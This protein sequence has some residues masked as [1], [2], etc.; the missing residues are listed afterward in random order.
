[1]VKRY[2]SNIE[3]ELNLCNIL[4]GDEGKVFYSPCFGPIRLSVIN[5]DNILFLIVQNS[6]IYEGQKTC[7][8][9]GSNGTYIDGGEVMVYPSKD[10][11]DWFEYDYIKRNSPGWDEYVKETG[12]NIAF[13]IIDIDNFISKN[14][15]EKSAIAYIKLYKIIKH[16]YNDTDVDHIEHVAIDPMLNI[17]YYCENQKEYTP[18]FFTTTL[19]AQDFLKNPKNKELINQFYNG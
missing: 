1:M 6:K 11:R 8:I 2:E 12:D 14:K 5:E 9:L 10:N 13:D 7:I 3:C 18:L 19:A 4:K 15:I 17:Q 16:F